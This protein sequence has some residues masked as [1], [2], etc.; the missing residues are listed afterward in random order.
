MSTINSKL[1]GRLVKLPTMGKNARRVLLGLARVIHGAGIA[2][3]TALGVDAF[4]WIPG[5][6]GYIA[7]LYFL[8]AAAFIA[9]AGYLVWCLGGGKK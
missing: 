7:V 5:A 8:A 1:P 2:A 4:T 9:G 3:I 6:E